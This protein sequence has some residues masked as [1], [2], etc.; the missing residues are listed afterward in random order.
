MGDYIG[1]E[2]RGDNTALMREL[3]KAVEDSTT[4][5]LTEHAKIPPEV[6]IK[7]HHWTQG[8]ID[9]EEKNALRKRKIVDNILGSAGVVILLTIL[10][11]FGAWI[12]HLLSTGGG[13]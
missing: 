9:S 13:H 3:R 10:G 4:K 5:A 2:R 8:K 7:H 11:S 1:E 6:H 12:R